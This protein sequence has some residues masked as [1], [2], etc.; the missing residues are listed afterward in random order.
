MGVRE[1][2]VQAEAAHERHRRGGPAQAL[3]LQPPGPGQHALGLCHPEPLRHAVLGAPD[4]NRVGG[5]E[6][7]SQLQPPE[8][9]QLMLGL[10]Q[11]QLPPRGPAA[12]EDRERRR[13]QGRPVQA[14]GA[15]ELD[16]G[17]GEAELQVRGPPLQRVPG[18]REKT[19]PVQPPELGEHLLGLRDSGLP[20]GAPDGQDHLPGG[21][22]H[23][24]LQ[25][26]GPLEHRVGPGEAAAQPRRPLPD[27]GGVRGDQENGHV[28]R[29]RDGQPFPGVCLLREAQQGSHGRDQQGSRRE[30]QHVQ[31]PRPGEPDVVLHQAR[32]PP[33]EGLASPRL[34]PRQRGGGVP[35]LRRGGRH[36]QRRSQQ[37]GLPCPTTGTSVLH[38]GKSDAPDGSPSQDEAEARRP[39]ALWLRRD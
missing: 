28:Q 25:P 26:A 22:L 16:L 20:P 12:G 4:R 38:N 9:R 11:A 14:P 1:A 27:E 17:H 35:L 7:D 34:L 8:P 31:R 13:R 36:Q 24:G 30:D 2:R 32:P 15:R 10:R 19:S 5:H 23:H 18:R 6:E 29:P 39:Q 3:R 21:P 33:A 37:P